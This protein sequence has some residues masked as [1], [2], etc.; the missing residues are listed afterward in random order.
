[1][2]Y[3]SE[4]DGLRAFAVISVILFHAGF[5]TFNGGFIGVDVFFVISGY[6]ISTIIIEEIEAGSFD[7]WSFYERRARRILP[8]LFL[9]IL[10]IFPIAYVWMLP[11]E[12]KAFSLSA[13][14][15]TLFFSNIFFWSQ[16][17]YFDTASELKPL[18]HTWSLGV[19]E[20][21]YII[22]PIFMISI[23]KKNRSQLIWRI[24]I[25]LII[26]LTLSEFSSYKFPSANFYLL[27]M[28]AWELLSGT[29]C[30]FVEWRSQESNATGLIWAPHD[31][32][33]V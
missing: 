5:T 28:R 10:C 16:S 13:V 4:I 8:A 21:F 7:F 23:W 6:L 9:V 15:A 3:R 29:L 20:Q 17:G 32:E 12:L 30:S 26:S 19:E 27:P 22:F 33:A 14:S 25:I 24:A 1:M 31:T 11:E 18:L 2:Q